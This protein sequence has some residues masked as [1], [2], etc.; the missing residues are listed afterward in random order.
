MVGVVVAVFGSAAAGAQLGQQSAPAA[1]HAGTSRLESAWGWLDG[2]VRR[3]PIVPVC[4]EGVPCDGPAAG[5]TVLITRGGAPVAR[6]I[7]DS[8]GRFHRRLRPGLYVVRALTLPG[9]GRGSDAK[10]V[11]VSSGR[12]TRVRLLI[13]TGIR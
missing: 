2:T 13:D 5:V 8:A 7:T 1:L 12:H 9:P 6:V 10:T 11:R 3:G 4:V